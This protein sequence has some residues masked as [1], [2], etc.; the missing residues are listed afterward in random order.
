MEANVQ[1]DYQTRTGHLLLADISGY[2]N[3]LTSTELEHA[4][5]IIRELITLVRDQLAPPMRFVQA[6]G[7]AVFCYADDSTFGDGE[8]L[9]ELIEVCYYEFSNRL[10][11]MSRNTTCSCAA[12]AAIGTL[13][14]KFIC[15]FGTFVVDRTESGVDV[16]GADVI[17][18]HRLLK[19]TVAE[20]TGLKAYAALTS[21][22]VQRLGL[23]TKMPLLEE[24]YESFGT[25]TIGVHDL[26]P[27]L[28]AMQDSHRRYV[29]PEDA[30]FTASV[31]VPIPPVEAWHY[32]LNPVQRQRWKCR[33]FS[34]KPD[35]PTR[36]TKGR[37]GAGAA[38]HCSHGPGTA[39]WEFVD[40][41][42]FTSVTH[43]V[44]APPLGPYL[45]LHDEI[46]TFDFVPTAEG[47]TR[48]VYRVRLKNR[49]RLTLLT[50]RI[51]RRWLNAFDR[52]AHQVLLEIIAEDA[53]KQPI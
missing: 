18:V 7:D 1:V 15:H 33:Y 11:N 21:A 44:T 20:R 47:G 16:A 37:I 34:K 45:G 6:E 50:Y 12:C 40:W 52:R 49:S 22:C 23:P 53:V 30:D 38:M 4:Q 41:R 43:E 17:L 13:D 39:R 25:T 32:Y 19:N 26:K 31:E 5:S 48:V 42:P 29:R 14:L 8:R 3:F 46:N 9:V 27:A 24:H 28:A 51:Q 35:V 2:T 36:N 10:L